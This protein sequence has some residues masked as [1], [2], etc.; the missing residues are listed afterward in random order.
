[1]KSR[2]KNVSLEFH[3]NVM[4]N[5]LR[6][7]FSSNRFFLPLSVSYFI[8][9]KCNLRCSYCHDLKPNYPE[10]STDQ[11]F[12]LLVKIRPKCPGLYI[13]GGEPLLRNDITP[14][15]KKAKEL[16][17]KP[18]W[19]IT[20]AFNIDKNIDC[21]EYLDYLVVSLDSLNTK[22]WDEI[23]GVNGAAIRIIN[24]IKSVAKLQDEYDFIMVANNVINK[25]LIDDAYDV[26]TF[27]DDND[28]YLAPQPI[29]SWMSEP[30]N[31]FSNPSYIQLIDDIKTIKRNG[32][33]NIVVSNVFLDTISRC[34]T[35]NCYPTMNPRIYPDGAVFYPCMNLDRIY[36]NLFN[37]NSLFELM[38]E[39]YNRDKLPECTRH[40]EICTRN[41]IVE[42]NLF[43]DKPISY[44]KDFLES[45][46]NNIRKR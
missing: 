37:Y 30:E 33:R 16:K 25:A 14:I 31:L 12:E 9:L 44:L 18:I 13:T 6:R 20:N 24:N 34:F 41:C 42:I 46:A 21:L 1:M 8:T 32:S 43:I 39:A 23:L 40:P 15:L 7:Y 26:I 45:G 3:K 19:M 17:F 11:I 4:C 29:D 10:L 22:K 38:E 27:C 2:L 28:I 5:L 35:K 36:D